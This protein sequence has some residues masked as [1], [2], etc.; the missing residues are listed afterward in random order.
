MIDDTYNMNPASARAA[1]CALAGMP[2][3]GSR[4]VVFGGMLELGPRSEAMHQELGEAVHRRAI[5]RL[6]CVGAG[7]EAIAEGA[8]RAGMD[9]ASVASV[10]DPTAAIELLMETLQPGDHVL[11]K[12]SRGVALERVVDGLLHRLEAADRGAAGAGELGGQAET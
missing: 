9:A 10:D 5:D 7:A 3:D 1:L 8:R 12:A 2:V 4:T 11:C 6:V